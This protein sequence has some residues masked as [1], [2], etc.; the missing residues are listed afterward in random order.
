VTDKYWWPV[1]EPGA[2]EPKRARR[3]VP[4]RGRGALLSNK[5]RPIAAYVIDGIKRPSALVFRCRV[6]DD[7]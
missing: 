6:T 2:D 5:R 1:P 4:S 3:P 7:P